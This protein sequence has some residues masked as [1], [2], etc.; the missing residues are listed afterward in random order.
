MNPAA[1][2]ARVKS[3]ASYVTYRAD[4]VVSGRSTPTLPLPWAARPVNC[5]ITEKSAVKSPA[6]TW[7][8]DAGVL[9]PPPVPSLDELDEPGAVHAAPDLTAAP[10]G[11]HQPALILY[12]SG[13]TSRPKGVVVP[14]AQLRA[15]LELQRERTRL[16][17]G[18]HVVNWLPAHHALGLGSVLLAHYVGGAATLIEP[19]DFVVARRP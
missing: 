2:N 15:T 1:L 10:L 6:L 16:P 4:V 8:T 9:L 13:S 14:H 11:A 7:G 5:F 3:G 17:D 19:A 12:T 18:G